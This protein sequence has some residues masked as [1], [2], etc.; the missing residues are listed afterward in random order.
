MN[1]LPTIG[2]VKTLGRI[3]GH[4]GGA[5]AIYR[6]DPDSATEYEADGYYIVQPEHDRVL[7]HTKDYNEALC[8]AAGYDEA[9]SNAIDTLKGE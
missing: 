5:T 2:K 8:Y 3:S 4:H 7:D 6:I 1:E 9:W